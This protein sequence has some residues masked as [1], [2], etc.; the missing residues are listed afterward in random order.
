MGKYLEVNDTLQITK[1][2]GFPISVFDLEKHRRDPVTVEDV[3]GKLFSFHSKPRARVFH[4]EPVRIFLVQNING[5]WL[6]WGHAQIQSQ[7]I[8]KVLGEDGAWTGD[9]QTNGTY[10]VD[11]VYEPDYQETFTKCES[12]PGRSYL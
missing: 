2:Q 4:L 5:K 12:P 10:I 6:F 8:V 11:D 3:K 9:W 7:E 1:E